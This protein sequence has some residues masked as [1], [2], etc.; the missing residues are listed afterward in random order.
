LHLKHGFGFDV[1]KG[2]TEERRK[3]EKKEE[4]GKKRKTQGKK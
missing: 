3:G 2:E 4:R 1:R